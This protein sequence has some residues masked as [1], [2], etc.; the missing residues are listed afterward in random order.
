MVAIPFEVSRS[1]GPGQKPRFDKFTVNVSEETPILTALLQIRSELDPSLGLRYSC[2]QAICGSCAMRVNGK[3]R[4]VCSTPVGPEFRAHG[5]V[6]IEP[7]ANQPVVKDLITDMTPFWDRYRRVHPHLILDPAHPLP[8][9]KESSMTPEQFDQFKETPRCIAC[10]ACYSACPALGSDDEFLGPMA[11]AKMYRFVVDPRDSAYRQRLATIQN[12][13]LWLCLRCNMCVEACPKDVR[14]AERIVD[15]KRLA[16]QELGAP[17]QG[18]RHAEKFMTNIEDGG[19]LNEMKLARETL[20]IFGTLKQIPKGIQ[21]M[22]HGRSLKKHP[23]IQGVQEVKVIYSELN[24]PEDLMHRPR[25]AGKGVKG[26][27]Q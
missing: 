1:A 22:R 14:P 26:G 15:L 24:K 17:E 12:Q 7:M 18:S 5:K 23:P 11:L 27:G 10:G 20:G 4:L 13:S 6:V 21:M 8:K 3:S 16:I 25:P 2:R 19:V 9:D